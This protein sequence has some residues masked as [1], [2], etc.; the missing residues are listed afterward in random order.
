MLSNNWNLVRILRLIFAVIISLEAIYSNTWWLFI[1]SGILL[2]QAV[3]N[4]G[5]PLNSCNIP[6]KEMKNNKEIQYEELGK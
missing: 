5:C 4:L 3:L 2:I 6:V 1:P